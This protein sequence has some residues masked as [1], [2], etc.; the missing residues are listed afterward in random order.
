M[1]TPRD[2]QVALAELGVTVDRV[3]G[4]EVWALCPM[5]EERTGKPDRK[6]SWSVNRENG[7]HKCFSCGYGGTF[8]E[9]VTDLTDL[10]IFEAYRWIRRHGV[11]ILNREEML[12]LRYDKQLA[13]SHPDEPEKALEISEASLALF[14]RPPIEEVYAR[15][16]TMESIERYDL[17]WDIYEHGWIIPVRMPDTT[18]IGWQF[19]SKRDFENYPQGMEKGLCVFGLELLEEG[20][21]AIVIEAPHDCCRVYDAGVE[22]DVGVP[23]STYGAEITDAQMAAIL[24][25][26]DSVIMALDNDTEGMDSTQRIAMGVEKRGKVT[27]RGWATRFRDFRVYNYYGSRAKDEGEQTDEEIWFGLTNAQTPSALRMGRYKDWS[28]DDGV[29]T[30]GRTRTGGRRN[31]AR[32]A[33]ARDGK[34]NGLRPVPRRAGRRN[35]P[36]ARGATRKRHTG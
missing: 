21:T 10:N 5:H 31:A 1:P 3:S 19:K 22:P 34:A 25:R 11:R 23:V 32:G 28:K 36:D 6:P 29:T 35:D 12:S 27:R 4:E 24:E 14:F 18:L 13:D 17:L 9:L 2:L 7:Y 20:Q 26:T 8:V 15:N 33:T 30:D 16:L